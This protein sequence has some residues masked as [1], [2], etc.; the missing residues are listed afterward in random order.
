MLFRSLALSLAGSA[1]VRP[2]GGTLRIAGEP[3]TLHHPGDGIAAG[4]AVVTADRLRSGVL[5]DF[6]LT[7]NLC[8][9]SLATFADRFGF[10]DATAQGASAIDAIN[11]LRIRCPGP[12]APIRTLSGGNQQKV[13][14]AKWLQTRPKVL[15]L[16]EPTLGVDVGSKDEIRSIIEAAARSGLGIVLMTTELPDLLAL[17]QRVLVMFRGA[18]VG[19]FHGVDMTESAILQ[20]ASGDLRQPAGAQS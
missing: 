1:E 4:M 2:S 6:S 8:L 9:P 12:S 16:D 11:R 20:A 3:C 15:I 17:C 19:Q 14:I 5:R 7:D 13:M 18:I 10:L